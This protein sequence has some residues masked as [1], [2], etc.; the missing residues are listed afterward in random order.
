MSGAHTCDDACTCPVHGTAL[1]Y[2]PAADDHACQDVTCEYGHGGAPYGRSFDLVP[3]HWRRG[4]PGTTAVDSLWNA[5]GV[6]ADD[7]RG[8]AEGITSLAPGGEDG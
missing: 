3:P 5:P 6:S 1:Y 4:F 2:A 8:L 7:L